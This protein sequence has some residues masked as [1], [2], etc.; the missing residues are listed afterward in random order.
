MPRS[1]RTAIIL[2]ILIHTIILYLPAGINSRS[3]VPPCEPYLFRSGGNVLLLYWNSPFRMAA[4][5]KWFFVHFWRRRYF[6]N[7]FPGSLK[8]LLVDKLDYLH[9]SA[10]GRTRTTVSAKEKVPCCKCKRTSQELCFKYR[11]TLRRKFLGFGRF[12]FMVSSYVQRQ[13]SVL[14]GILSCTYVIAAELFRW[15]RM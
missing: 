13:Y 5:R 6:Y 14:Y 1:T 15:T 12:S 4:S 8:S 11:E 9:D 7:N 10:T 2:R 3:W